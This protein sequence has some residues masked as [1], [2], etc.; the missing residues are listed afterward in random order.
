MPPNNQPLSDDQWHKIFDA[1]DAAVAADPQ[2]PLLVGKPEGNPVN[3]RP[4]WA[5]S[6]DT[7]EQGVT[8]TGGARW[9]AGIQNPRQDFKS[10][11]LANNDGWKAGVTAAVSQDRYA[12]G[13]GA[14]NVD[15]AIATALKIGS[16]G[17]QAGATA[18]KAKYAAKTQAIQA[19]MG[20][21]V[22]KA[23][24]MPAK[25]LQDRINRAVTMIQGAAAV[26]SR[27]K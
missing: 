5:P 26:G 8:T 21:V 10:A 20:A 1:A 25:T 23:R 7:W 14:V 2:H 27:G 12:K 24:S 17:Y 4:P 22:T 16:A 6:A 3:T 18:R 11:A 19:A 13:M 15:D 9:E